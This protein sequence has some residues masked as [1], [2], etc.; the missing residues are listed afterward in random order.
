MT[1]C[2]VCRGEWPY[3][4]EVAKKGGDSRW[5]RDTLFSPKRLKHGLLPQ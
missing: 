4:V 3:D 5:F 2:D 1:C